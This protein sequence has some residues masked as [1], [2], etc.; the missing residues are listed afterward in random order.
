MTSLSLKGDNSNY[1]CICSIELY[2]EKIKLSRTKH[3]NCKSPK[4]NDLLYR[5]SDC[6]TL[7]ALK[8]LYYSFIHQHFL[9]DIIFWDSVAKCDFESIF[10]LQKKAM[11]MLTKSPRYAHTDPIFVNK[12]IL[13]LSSILKFEFCKFIHSDLYKNI[14]F[15]LTPRPLVNSYNT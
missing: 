12:D 1:Y 6:F 11:R 4:L 14:I 3:V 15:N 8:N 2:V 9:Y 7:V 13:K 10:R 5:V